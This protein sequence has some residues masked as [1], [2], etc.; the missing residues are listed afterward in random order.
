MKIKLK[1]QIKIQLIELL[2]LGL[3]LDTDLDLVSS[4]MDKGLPPPNPN[5]A[6]EGVQ[7]AVYHYNSMV[8]IFILQTD[9]NHQTAQVCPR[10]RVQCS[11]GVQKELRSEFT[12]VVIQQ[13]THTHQTFP[14]NSRSEQLTF[15]KF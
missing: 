8:Y 13:I 12:I 2:H 7:I 1:M 5:A 4:L 15:A 10:P 9:S 14:T 11:R 3:G 6:G